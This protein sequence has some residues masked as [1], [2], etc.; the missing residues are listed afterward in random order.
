MVNELKSGGKQ[1]KL[2]KKLFIFIF[3]LILTSV[4][5]LTFFLGGKKEYASEYCVEGIQLFNKDKCLVG[6]KENDSFRYSQNY[7][8][9][10]NTTVWMNMTV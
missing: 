1:M 8:T 9:D 6:S 2:N 10:L 3:C 7:I 4:A 5:S